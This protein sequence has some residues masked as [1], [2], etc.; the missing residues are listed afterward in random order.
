MAAEAETKLPTFNTNVDLDEETRAEMITVLNQSLA[1]VFDLYSQTKQAHW[2]VKG[3]QFIALHQ[4]FD[5]L[6]A[7]VLEYV[8]MIAERITALGGY[9]AG[10]V[11]M[12]ADRSTLPEWPL[13]ANNGQAAV[14]A[15]VERYAAYA[16]SA[17][18]LIEVTDDADDEVSSDLMTEITRGMDKHLYFLQ[19][20]LQA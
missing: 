20:H 14:E 6:A 2:N 4:L 17:R 16:N 1:D 12:A 3:M 7:S 10:T 15:L 9:A 8:D 18:E 5:D 11:G 19:A 13:D